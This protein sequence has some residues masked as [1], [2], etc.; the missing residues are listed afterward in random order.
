MIPSRP[1]G[2]TGLNVSCVGFGGW[3]I[4]GRTEGT[5]SYGD[6]DDETSLAALRAAID[7]GMTFID[8]SPAYGNGHSETLIGTVVAEGARERVTLATKAGYL[9]WGQEP[10]FS[11]AAIKRSLDD[12]LK[13]LRTDTVDLLQLHNA[14]LE[15]LKAD[16]TI[17]ATLEHWN[18][19]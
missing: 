11:A 18:N 13:R 6:T 12:S 3:G 19:R 8:T 7:Q 2:A 5:T 4:G 10:D 1:L 9:R 16:R 17:L 15:L 14:P